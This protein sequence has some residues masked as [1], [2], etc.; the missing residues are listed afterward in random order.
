MLGGA[1]LHVH[2][3]SVRVPVWLFI[4]LYAVLVTSRLQRRSD[5][6]NWGWSNRLRSL[7][8]PVSSSLVAAPLGLGGRGPHAAFAGP[9]KARH[10]A[11]V[12]ARV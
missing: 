2:V 11:F 1:G 8:M 12:S 5:P 4:R 9:Q 3:R 10:P 6:E 7:L